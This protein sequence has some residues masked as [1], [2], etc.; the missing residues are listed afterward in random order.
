MSAAVKKQHTKS[1]N[2]VNPLCP[3]LPGTAPPL[4]RHRTVSWPAW[5]LESMGGQ[6]L[7]ADVKRKEVSGQR[8]QPIICVSA[9]IRACIELT[10]EGS[11][12]TY[13]AHS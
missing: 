8:E 5:Q 4:L 10:C 11:G 12:E 6:R 1:P 7:G 9:C 2:R 13:V 3:P